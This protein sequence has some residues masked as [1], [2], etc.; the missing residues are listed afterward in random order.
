MP[1][2]GS[3]SGSIRFQWNPNKIG[4]PKVQANWTR[5]ATAGREQPF[6]HYASGGSNMFN[7]S[8]ELSRYDNGDEYVKDTIERII[9]LTKP[10]VK[11][12]GVSHPPRI[13]LIIGT[14]L[15]KTCVLE[16][17]DPVCMDLFHPDTLNPFKAEVSLTLAE[18][19]HF[20]FGF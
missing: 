7:I 3:G 18:Y 11:G 1:L 17:V 20:G 16:S 13:M 4:G 6:M 14:F 8:I 5:V 15:R 19:S 10:T 9:S 12:T 2:E